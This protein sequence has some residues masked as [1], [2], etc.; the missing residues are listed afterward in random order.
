MVL[1]KYGI[2]FIYEIYTINDYN[3]VTQ[4]SRIVHF[5]KISGYWYKRAFF[6]RQNRAV[7]FFMGRRVSWRF[8]AGVVLG[9]KYTLVPFLLSCRL[10]LLSLWKTLESNEHSDDWKTCKNKMGY[11]F[12]PNK[13]SCYL[14]WF[15]RF[16]LTC[17]NKWSHDSN[18]EWCSF[19]DEGFGQ[20]MAQCQHKR[21]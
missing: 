5:V 19:V 6:R 10:L 7:L 12:F 1:E 18:S 8:S 11:S 4:S 14:W 20:K 15:W 17:N 21:P 9:Q 16:I 3:R 2:V 13:Q